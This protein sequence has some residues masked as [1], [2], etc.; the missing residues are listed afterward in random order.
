[1]LRRKESLSISRT[2]GFRLLFQ[3][4]SDSYGVYGIVIDRAFIR[5][6]DGIWKKDHPMITSQSI[7][8]NRPFWYLFLEKGHFQKR[9]NRFIKEGCWEFF[10]N[11]KNKKYHGHLSEMQVGDRVAIFKEGGRESAEEFKSIHK[12]EINRTEVQYT[13]IRAIGKITQRDNNII[14]VDWET[15]KDSRKWYSRANY[16]TIWKVHPDSIIG[17]G[18]NLIDFTFLGK[19]QNLGRLYDEL[20]SKKGKKIVT[21]ETY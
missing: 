3:H 13:F 4:A 5:L 2:N 21:K 1:M 17:W 8:Y 9:Y 19:D 6:S 16:Y 12:V 18:R 11:E 15:V 20:K 7:D 10:D 14:G